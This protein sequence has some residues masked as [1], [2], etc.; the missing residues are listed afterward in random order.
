MLVGYLELIH[1]RLKLLLRSKT[2]WIIMIVI[3]IVITTFLFDIKS[4]ATVATSGPNAK[5]F[6]G[7]LKSINNVAR[8]NNNLSFVK[9][10][11]RQSIHDEQSTQKTGEGADNVWVSNPNV[12][13]KNILPYTD[14]IYGAKKNGNDKVEVIHYENK[15]GTKIV[16]KLIN[17]RDAMRK[18]NNDYGD[19]ILSQEYETFK[20][21]GTVNPW[22]LS[23]TPSKKSLNNKRKLDNMITESDLDPKIT[24]RLLD[25]IESEE[26]K[27]FSDVFPEEEAEK[28]K[29]LS[30][31]ELLLH[32]NKGIEISTPT[33]A[34]LSETYQKPNNGNEDRIYE[35]AGEASNSTP[36]MSGYEFP[37]QTIDEILL[38]KGP[39]H[40]ER[41]PE[42]EQLSDKFIPLTNSNN[43]TPTETEL[44]ELS[45]E[46]S[47]MEDRN[48]T[49]DVIA[50][51]GSTFN[52]QDKYLDTILADDQDDN[53]TQTQ[54]PEDNSN[55]NAVNHNTGN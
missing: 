4:T 21:T 17:L 41:S 23:S 22:H 25:E 49:E 29:G 36:K 20:K 11:R 48:N 8:R 43:N 45:R 38:N 3:V 42:I 19:R 47:E 31:D 53:N 24:H 34:N 32:N 35:N 14:E 55:E 40:N 37:Q 13:M 46:F 16:D 2:F 5:A 18:I 27:L 1:F 54:L 26:R 7:R 30:D 28:D 44:E 33:N 6:D 39:V 15:T 51:D 50:T 10:K 9:A 12:I 52:N